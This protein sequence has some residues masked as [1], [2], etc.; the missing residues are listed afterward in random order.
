MSPAYV[1]PAAEIVS[2]AGGSA[3]ILP[4]ESQWIHPQETCPRPRRARRKR[5]P[6]RGE[7]TAAW[8]EGLQAASV[9]RAQAEV[10][11][12]GLLDEADPDERDDAHDDHVDRD[13]QGCSGLGEQGLGDGRGEGAAE[14]RTERVADRDPRIA[15]L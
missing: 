11:A 7:C 4:C 9:V 1:R 12:L 14:D 2:P 8:A 15:D 10:D 5:S 3:L 6:R 13:R